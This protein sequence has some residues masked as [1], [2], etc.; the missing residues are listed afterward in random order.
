MFDSI[1][2]LAP[3]GKTCY[4]GPTGLDSSAVSAYFGKYGA[5]PDPGANPAEHLIATVAPGEEE[6]PSRILFALHL[7]H[8]ILQT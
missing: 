5:A 7:T 3:G 4:A 1:L 2:L 6:C 8:G